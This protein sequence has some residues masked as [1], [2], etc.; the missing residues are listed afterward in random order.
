VIGGGINGVGIA[1]DAAGRGLDVS[2]CEM[3]D[4]ASG[5]SSKSSKLIHGGLRY[6]E[7]CHFRLVREALLERELLLKKAPHIIAPLRFRLPHQPHLRSALLIRIGLFLY[8][9][10]TRLISFKGSRSIKFDPQGPLVP[11]IKHGFEYSDAW[12]DDS[13]LVLLNA[14]AA[15]ELGVDIRTRCR[16]VEARRENGLWQITLQDQYSGQCYLLQA[17]A[18]VNAAGPW[19]SDIFQNVLTKSAQQSV[20]LV[21]GSHIIVKRIHDET[22]AYLLQN[23]DHRIVFVIPYEKNFSLIGTTDIDYQGDPMAASTSEQ[24]I[25]Y[26]IDISNQYFNQKIEHKDIVKSYVGVRTLIDDKAKNAQAVSRDYILDVEDVNSS[27]PLLS[28]YGGKITSYRKLAETSVN[29]LS[30]YFHQL[31]P[32]WTAVA[33][34]PGGGFSSREWLAAQYSSRYPWLPCNL[35]ERYV[36]SYGTLANNILLPCRSFDDLG[37]CFGA[38]LYQQEVDYLI[39]H[40]WVRTSEDLL[41]RR[42]K[43]GLLLDREQNDALEYYI[44]GVID[45]KQREKSLSSDDK[46]PNKYVVQG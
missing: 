34:L 3:D 31:G 12:V 30:D 40:E 22:Q 27:A 24:E 10:L 18:L 14:I 8:D 39:E 44:C 13:R 9:H 19:V 26:L 38:D 21:K 43:L 42:S 45:F 7:N 28:V 4:L 11:T 20:R 36:R 16:C 29:K 2:L 23:E 25:N 46:P 6:L 33:I 5:T 37:E 17:R 35:I 15:K 41:W 1:L 32:A